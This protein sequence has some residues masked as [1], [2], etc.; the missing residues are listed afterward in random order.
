MGR[1]EDET[2]RLIKNEKLKFEKDIWNQV[3]PESIDLIRKLLDRNIHNRINAEE[4]LKHPWFT[5]FELKQ[6]YE[7]VTKEKITM[8]I[9]NLKAYKTNYKLQESAIAIIVHNI[10]HNDEIKELEKAFRNIDT[11]KDGKL[12][13]EEMENGFNSIFPDKNKRR[14]YKRSRSNI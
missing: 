3:S 13:K 5:R 9:N 11:N 7:V 12:T 14:K 1:D 2:F 6:K 4:A 10:P 8:F